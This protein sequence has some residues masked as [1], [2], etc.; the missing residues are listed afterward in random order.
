MWRYQAG[1]GVCWCRIVVLLLTLCLTS[2]CGSGISFEEFVG[3]P[4]TEA[5]GYSVFPRTLD[6]VRGL[7]IPVSFPYFGSTFSYAHVSA[8]MM[9][10]YNVVC[11]HS[12]YCMRVVFGRKSNV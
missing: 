11:I 7:P 10:N 6:L 1:G 8:C 5:N 3:Y 4:F 2:K 12:C 9:Y